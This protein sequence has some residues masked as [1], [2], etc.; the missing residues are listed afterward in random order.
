[1]KNLMNKNIS[2]KEL[3]EEMRYYLNLDIKVVNGVEFPV[4]Q[5]EIR[6]PA[7]DGYTVLEDGNY[8]FYAYIIRK[9]E[10][11][12]FV[13]RMSE[14]G[15]YITALDYLPVQEENGIRWEVVSVEKGACGY[16]FA[17]YGIT[18]E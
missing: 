15:C 4:E 9:E 8:P 11:S 1:M 14:E 2:S 6:L 13:W 12:D 7:P 5:E 3:V 17:P 16:S 18:I 10:A